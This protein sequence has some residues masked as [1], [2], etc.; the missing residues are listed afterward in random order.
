MQKKATLV[1]FA[2]S[3]AF[4]AAQFAQGAPVTTEGTGVGKHGDVVAAVTFDEGRIQSIDIKKSNENP[5]LAAKVF[6][7]MKAAMIENNTADIDLISGATVSSEALRDAVKAAAE[8]AGVT[9]GTK[10]LFGEAGEVIPAYANE[11]LDLVVMGSH[12]YGNFTAA[13]MGSTAMHLA[14][15]S[16]KPILV[17]RKK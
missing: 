2:L 9:L 17:I 4:G 14:A 13:V 6:T 8:K 12:G 11:S 7:D 3:L 15:R 16:E 1:A 10:L 5:I